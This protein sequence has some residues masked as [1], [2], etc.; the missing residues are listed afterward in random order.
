MAVAGVAWVN[1]LSM[2]SGKL[3]GS[4]YFRGQAD[5][6]WMLQPNVGRTSPRL[7]FEAARERKLFADFKRDAPRFVDGSLNDYELLAIGQ[8]YGLPTRLLDWT[9]N[10]LVAAWF[11]CES[12]VHHRDA[13]LHMIRIIDG[14]IV[15]IDERS[16]PLDPK[17]TDPVLVRIPPRVV[18]I[19]SQE[20]V[21]SVHGRP[22]EPWYPDAKRHMYDVL[23]IPAGEKPFFRSALHILGFNRGRLM[24]GLDG[25]C[26]TLAWRYRAN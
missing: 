24:P 12:E 5:A 21:F 16:D 14:D 2:I 23:D 1:F 9:T 25:L 6:T 17:L 20:G 19:T 22:A 13:R 11:A 26:A 8:H 10:P 18:R 4:W 3:D 15:D 7:P